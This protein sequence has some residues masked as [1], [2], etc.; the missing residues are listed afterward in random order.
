MVETFSRPGETT[1]SIMYSIYVESPPQ[2]LIEFD[3]HGPQQTTRRPVI[4]AI[5]CYEPVEG[6]LDIVAKGGKPTREAIGR[7]PSSIAF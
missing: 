1:P 5:V 6:T 3:E 2:S 7:E 4:E